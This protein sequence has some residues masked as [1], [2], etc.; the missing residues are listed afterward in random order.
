MSLTQGKNFRSLYSWH[1][2]TQSR[3]ENTVLR[4]QLLEKSEDDPSVLSVR[5]NV[6]VIPNAIVADQFNPAPVH[7]SSKTSE[8]F[9]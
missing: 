6:Y 5:R 7:K 8:K 4:G 9:Q 1:V 2:L 3:R